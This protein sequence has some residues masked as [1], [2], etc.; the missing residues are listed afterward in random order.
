M[1]GLHKDL[2]RLA[3][4]I[5]PKHG[6]EVQLEFVDATVFAKPGSFLRASDRCER[7]KPGKNPPGGKI[8]AIGALC[9]DS[10]SFLH[11]TKSY[12][13]TAQL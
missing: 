12:L 4:G 6:Q 9:N 3:V 5:E 11:E 13:R 10:E 7:K 2:R 1:N 8:K